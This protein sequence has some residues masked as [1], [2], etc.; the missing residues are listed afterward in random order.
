VLW[1]KVYKDCVLTYIIMKFIL[2]INKVLIIAMAS[3]LVT[4]IMFFV[5]NDECK[6][7]QAACVTSVGI[8]VWCGVLFMSQVIT[9]LYWLFYLWTLFPGTNVESRHQQQVLPRLKATTQKLWQR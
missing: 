5:L 8:T 2:P 7:N 9:V 3:T 1:D 6:V 4:L